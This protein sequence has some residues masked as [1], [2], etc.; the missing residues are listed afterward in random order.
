MS[1]SKKINLR[2]AQWFGTQGRWCT[3]KSKSVKWYDADSML[4]I[5]PD[6]KQAQRRPPSSHPENVVQ[7]SK[8]AGI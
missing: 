4:L 1:E 6:A 3:S 8:L 5:P 7:G 2:S